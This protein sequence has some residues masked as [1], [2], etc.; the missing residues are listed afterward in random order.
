MLLAASCFAFAIVAWY[1]LRTPA[2]LKL[3][4]LRC[5]LEHGY[6]K[7]ALENSPAGH[8]SAQCRFCCD[9][10]TYDPLADALNETFGG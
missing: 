8:G 5:G 7:F 4:S 10:V 9:T 1:M 2:S 3:P 6:L